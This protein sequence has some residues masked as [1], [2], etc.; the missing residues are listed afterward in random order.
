VIPKI[1]LISEIIDIGEG[2]AGFDYGIGFRYMFSVC[3]GGVYKK[4]EDD[5]REKLNNIRE[6][7]IE[8]VGIYYE[9]IKPPIKW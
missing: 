5:N 6:S 7:I 3:A 2:I 4:F 8:H 9:S 1:S